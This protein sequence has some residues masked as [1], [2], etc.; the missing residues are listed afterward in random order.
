[1]PK[2]L[3]GTKQVF[4]KNVLN[5]SISLHSLCDTDGEKAG[6]GEWKCLSSRSKAGQLLSLYPGFLALATPTRGTENQS[7]MDQ[8]RKWW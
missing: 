7:T 4:S 5:Y 8:R 1:M 6:T 3:F 2:T